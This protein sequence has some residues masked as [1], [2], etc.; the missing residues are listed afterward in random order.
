M[1]QRPSAKK[2]QRARQ[3][4]WRRAIIPG[5]AAF[6][7]IAV[8]AALVWAG[9]PRGEDASQAAAVQR[10]GG[11]HIYYGSSCH[12]C[13]PYVEE[14]AMPALRTRVWSGPIEVHDFMKPEGRQALARTASEVGLTSLP[15]AVAEAIAPATF[16][17]AVLDLEKSRVVLLGHPPGDLIRQVL[18]VGEL[19]PRLILSQGEMHIADV[20]PT[21]YEL[22]DFRGAVASFPI[23]TPVKDALARLSAPR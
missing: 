2:Q 20:A 5:G 1:H 9:S 8:V 18:A 13:P 4:L 15:P 17:F 3:P 23:S 14:H 16:H 6:L 12:D 19:P 7:G 11:V 21:T 22:W 10:T